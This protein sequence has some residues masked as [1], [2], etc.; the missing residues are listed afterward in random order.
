MA[1]LMKGREVTRGPRT[2]PTEKEHDQGANT[3]KK[4]TSARKKELSGTWGAT[5]PLMLFFVERNSWR[6]CGI[7]NSSVLIELGI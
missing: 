5:V 1:L 6:T 3:E 4:W 7:E 2:R